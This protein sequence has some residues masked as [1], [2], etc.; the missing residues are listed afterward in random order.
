MFLDEIV[1][2]WDLGE[3]CFNVGIKSFVIVYILVMFIVK[4][5][6]NLDIRIVKFEF[7]IVCVN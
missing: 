5:V 7:I 2:I 6:F 1:I 4:F 3:V